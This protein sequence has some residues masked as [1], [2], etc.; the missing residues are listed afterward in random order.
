MTGRKIGRVK[1]R[2]PKAV[3]PTPKP[4]T[5]TRKGES[6]LVLLYTSNYEVQRHNSLC[7]QVG[8]HRFHFKLP[9][10]IPSKRVG[11]YAQSKTSARKTWIF[12]DAP[13]KLGFIYVFSEGVINLF[14]GVASGNLKGFNRDRMISLVI[15]WKRY[16]LLSHRVYNLDGTLHEE[17][18]SRWRRVKKTYTDRP[19]KGEVEFTYKKKTQIQVIYCVEEKVWCKYSNLISFA[20]DRKSILAHKYLKLELNIVTPAGVSKICVVEILIKSG[21]ATEDALRRFMTNPCSYVP[22]IEKL[23]LRGVLAVK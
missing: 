18:Y 10:F 17:K 15:P 21:E 9:K 4:Y 11:L 16:T 8:R 14:H 1:L 2:T 12:A 20:L 19:V 6:G 23:D 5:Y 7:I 13:R 22:L 3:E